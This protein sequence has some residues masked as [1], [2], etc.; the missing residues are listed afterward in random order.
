M[1]C[2]LD[3]L[4]FV[5]VNRRTITIPKLLSRYIS[6]PADLSSFSLFRTNCHLFTASFQAYSLHF[7]VFSIHFSLY[8]CLK[9]G[10]CLCN[11]FYLHIFLFCSHFEPQCR[12]TYSNKDYYFSIPL[13]SLFCPSTQISFVS[14]LLRP[15][16]RFNLNYE[17]SNL[18]F[19]LSNQRFG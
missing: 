3:M 16:L 11:H 19:F 9:N 13:F 4:N 1:Y 5:L 15:I 6:T 10:L 17:G 2:I 7:Q 18:L 8:Y 12:F 14:N